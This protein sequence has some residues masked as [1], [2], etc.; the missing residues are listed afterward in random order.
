MAQA[1]KAQQTAQDAL[2]KANAAIAAAKTEAEK[3]AAADLK[4]QVEALKQQTESRLKQIEA[5]LKA[6]QELKNQSAKLAAEKQKSYQQAQ[7]QDAQHQTADQKAQAALAEAQKSSTGVADSLK[8]AQTAKQSSEAAA[9]AAAAA[10][11]AADAAKA[12][13]TTA[14]K[15]DAVAKA[16]ASVQAAEAANTAAQTAAQKAQTAV[17]A[18]QAAKTQA[19][20]A[21]ANATAATKAQAQALQAQAAK[22]LAEAQSLKQAA[23]K[24]AAADKAALAAANALQQEVQAVYDQI[25]AE[26]KK[27]LRGDLDQK[28]A[29]LSKDALSNYSSKAPYE[30]FN[31]SEIDIAVADDFSAQ[32][33]LY[34]HSGIK[35]FSP[36]NIMRKE[37]GDGWD[38][39]DITS[40]SY[41]GNFVLAKDSYFPNPLTEV[42]RIGTEVYKQAGLDYED[43]TTVD[44]LNATTSR[45]ARV[46]L[47][48]LSEVS[49]TGNANPSGDIYRSWRLIEYPLLD[50]LPGVNEIEA[51]V[52]NETKAPFWK[53]SAEKKSTALGGRLLH[54][55][56][57]EQQFY[58][59]TGRRVATFSIKE[60]D[61]YLVLGGRTEGYDDEKGDVN[62]SLGQYFDLKADDIA[63]EPGIKAELIGFEPGTRYGDG[64]KIALPKGEYVVRHDALNNKYLIEKS[65]PGE[66]FFYNSGH[67]QG[68]FAAVEQVKQGVF[69]DKRVLAQRFAYLSDKQ[70]NDPKVAIYSYD[71]GKANGVDQAYLNLTAWKYKDGAGKYQAGPYNIQVFDKLGRFTNGEQNLPLYVDDPH[72]PGI[73]G[74]QATYSGLAYNSKDGKQD[75]KLTLNAKFTAG[76]DGFAQKVAVNGKITNR[77]LD[78]D[79]QGKPR[80]LF[81]ASGFKQQLQVA[82]GMPQANAGKDVAL[83][84][85]GKDVELTAWMKGSHK[86]EAATIYGTGKMV[87]GGPKAQ[88][89]GGILNITTH[90]GENR[91][92]FIGKR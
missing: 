85:A 62:L 91:I 14:A 82:Q 39:I 11:T 35:V 61:T 57:V 53:V 69:A 8:A 4:K 59:L 89:A 17:N 67:G 71:I 40:D 63:I 88:E 27:A 21:V 66:P 73:Q 80:D 2:N 90:D 78:K 83:R 68:F 79:S 84:A 74:L 52:D 55:P 19:D 77:R 81:F 87:F 48:L 75:G 65:I 47:A 58:D 86:D 38:K 45:F 10:K 13:S 60:P 31:S 28:L 30:L 92:G 29:Q 6:S 49:P 50:V 9:K 26:R 22:Q 15:A 70:S 54:E 42:N 46:G 76:A 18:A 32:P 23:D 64:F 24:Q 3:T 12:G 7:A 36:K 43:G 41:Q 33:N 72:K 37:V 34:V 51:F 5:Q 25:E 56:S 44:I 20:Q 16:N 1:Q